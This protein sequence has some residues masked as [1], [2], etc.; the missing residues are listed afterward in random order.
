MPGYTGPERRLAPPC[1]VP[2]KPISD[3]LDVIEECSRK[4]VPMKIFLPFAGFVLLGIGGAQWAIVEKVGAINTNL[5]VLTS[6]VAET[7]SDIRQDRILSNHMDK[8]IRELELRES[9]RHP[10]YFNQW[11]KD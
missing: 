8:R 6:T 5:A 10:E 4:K 2:C 9:S 1:T 3:K 7:K 11:N